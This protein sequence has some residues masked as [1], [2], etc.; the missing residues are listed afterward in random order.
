MLLNSGRTFKQGGV[1]EVVDRRWMC[2][3]TE[4]FSRI[5]LYV[6]VALFCV[7]GSGFVFVF[8]L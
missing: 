5:F 3:N 4:M 8:V 2:I 6:C 1:R 7:V